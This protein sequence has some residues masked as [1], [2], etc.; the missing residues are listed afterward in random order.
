MLVANVKLAFR[1]VSTCKKH[2]QRICDLAHGCCMDFRS[3]KAIVNLVASPAPRYVHLYLGYDGFS[4]ACLAFFLHEIRCH[5]VCPCCL[6]VWPSLEVRY[7]FSRSSA[8]YHRL[9]TLRTLF[10]IMGS[11]S[12]T[13]ISGWVMAECSCSVQIISLACRCGPKRC[14]LSAQYCCRFLCCPHVFSSCFSMRM[15][16]S[17]RNVDS[18][19]LVCAR[20][21]FLL[22]FVGRL[23]VLV[24][25]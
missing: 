4:A 24:R 16:D 1:C 8:L 25:M 10:G 21:C 7:I 23:C 3:F 5:S 18:C 20:A 6:E 22:I 14:F 19:V 11:R 17:I 13:N 15:Y 12:L 2:V 9:V